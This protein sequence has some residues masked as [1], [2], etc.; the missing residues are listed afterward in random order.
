M[1]WFLPHPFN[2]IEVDY[3]SSPC[4][5]NN[6]SSFK[7]SSLWT[8]FFLILIHR[9]LFCN[10][11]QQ[12]N[13][14]GKFRAAK[15]TFFFFLALLLNFIFLSVHKK[16]APDL[17]TVWARKF[18]PFSIPATSITVNWV[19]WRQTNSQSNKIIERF[20]LC[21]VTKSPFASTHSQK[22]Q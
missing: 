19:K 14:I 22:V 18:N 17:E 7:V 2:N 10:K 13:L 4:W 16:C 9:W 3:L 6:L 12:N 15:N 21:R 8:F 20:R 1:M 5:D 11:R